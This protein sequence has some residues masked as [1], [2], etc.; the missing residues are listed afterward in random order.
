MKILKTILFLLLISL[1]VNASGYTHNMFVAHK[2]MQMVIGS[3]LVSVKEVKVE[4]NQPIKKIQASVSITDQLSDQFAG[5]STLNQRILQDSKI[6]FF[7]SDEKE[8]TGN[9]IISALIN[10]LQSILYL[11]LGIPK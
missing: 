9:T 7:Y 6:S 3:E 4:V 11:F 5:F 2:K 1:K 8:Q 10:T